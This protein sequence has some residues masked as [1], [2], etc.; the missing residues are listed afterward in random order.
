M[1]KA[2]NKTP[3]AMADFFDSR[4]STYEQH[5]KE[6]TTFEQFYN[7]IAACIAR[8]KGKLSILDIGCGTGLELE[9]IFSIAPKAQIIGIDVSNEMLNKLKERYRAY[10]GQ[11][12]LKT[13]SYLTLPLGKNKYDYVVSVMTLHH[14]L[15]ETKL[16]IYQKIKNALKTG[17][18]YI[19]GDFIVSKSEAATMMRKFQKWQK[20]FSDMTDGTHHI[21]I[22]C[23]ID[24]QKQL[25]ERAGFSQ[26]EVILKEEKAAIITAVA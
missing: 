22:P 12:M 23:T 14:L 15:P 5:M 17:G 9:Y 10:P 11:V 7:T 8:T 25:L 19:E 1:S 16:K 6:S 4:A 3:E 21:D 26:I 2:K 18:K 24:T 20:T 13:D